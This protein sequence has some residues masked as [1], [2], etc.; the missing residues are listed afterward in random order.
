M[1]QRSTNGSIDWS[2]EGDGLAA[3]AVGVLEANWTGRAT[4]PS[5]ALYPHQWS[6]D[7]ACIAIG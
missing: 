7:S 5:P 4:M 3:G 1:Q 2:G 6:W